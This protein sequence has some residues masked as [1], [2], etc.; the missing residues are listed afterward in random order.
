MSSCLKKKK[1]SKQTNKNKTKQ[2]KTKQKKTKGR[3]DG[4]RKLTL[5]LSRVWTGRSALLLSFDWLCTMTE[6]SLP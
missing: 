2:N 5:T 3:H 6:C 4:K 1:K